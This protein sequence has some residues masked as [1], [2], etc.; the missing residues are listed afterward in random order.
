MFGNVQQ[1]PHFCLGITGGGS[2]KIGAITTSAEAQLHAKPSQHRTSDRSAW[3]RLELIFLRSYLA[4]SADSQN[5]LLAY[6]KDCAGA[7]KLDGIV[8]LSWAKAQLTAASS[9]LLYRY[10]C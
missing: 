6:E 3:C 4:T 10:C 2:P 1:N 9:R 5:G 7:A 8:K